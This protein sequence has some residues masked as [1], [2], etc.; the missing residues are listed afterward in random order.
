M[1]KVTWKQLIAEDRTVG[2]Y[3]PIHLFIIFIG[4]YLTYWKFWKE[5]AKERRILYQSSMTGLSIRDR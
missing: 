3:M 1:R 4:S 2:K 5:F